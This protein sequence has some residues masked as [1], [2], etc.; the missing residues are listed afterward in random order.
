MSRR[1]HW[2]LGALLWAGAR[3]AVA[4][5]TAADITLRA[6]ARTPNARGPLAAAQALQPGIAPPVA[7]GLTVQTELR[8]ALRGRLG[9]TAVALHGNAL[10]AHEWLRGR[11][12][13]DRS[14]VNELQASADLGAW[15]LAAGKKVLG[16]DVGYGFRP[17]DLV[18]QEERRTQF[19][20]TPEGRP[21]LMAEHFGAESAL[22]L[23]W[24]NP[25]R[26]TDAPAAQRFARESALAARAYLRQG[27]V[28]LHAFARHGRHTGASLGAAVAWVATDELELHGSVRALQRHDGW[29]LDP[30]AGTGL[31]TTPPWQTTLRGGAGQWLIGAQW[32]GAWQQSVLLEAWHDGTALPDA[33]WQAWSARHQALAAFATRPGLPAAALSGAA[34]NLAWQA[35][36]FDAPSLRQRNVYARLAWQPEHWQLSLDSLWQPADGG[37]IV[38]AAVQWQGDHW[39]VNASWR[40]YGGPQGALLAQ[41]PTRRSALLAATRSF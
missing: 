19:G 23:V 31:Q 33:E 1:P 14:R 24:V 15:Q 20:Q 18:Q 12:Q 26:W 9:G 2:L 41:L 35:A 39:R 22:S 37:R 38:T 36:P 21:L 34:G 3:L 13:A 27:A 30:A 17:N 6:D 28:D 5:D 7:D 16:W 8:H 11:G 25:Q 32:T 40:V 10:L 4:D 29:R